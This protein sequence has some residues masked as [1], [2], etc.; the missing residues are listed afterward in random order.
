MCL[1]PLTMYRFVNP[2]TGAVCRS[3]KAVPETAL[4]Y[5]KLSLPCGKCIECLQ[6]YSVEWANRC[7]LEAS[8][9]KDNCVIALTYSE[10]DGSLCRRD[11][12]LF[13]KRL[14]KAVSVPLRFFYCGEYGKRGGRP[15]Y[16]VIVFG[17]KPPDL[18]FF[19]ERDGHSVYKSAFVAR[20]WSDGKEWLSVPRKAGFISVED[21]TS[22]SAKY[23]AKY[24]QK[25]NSI[26]DGLVK[27]FTGMSLKPAIG[28]NGFNPSWFESDHMYINGRIC[29]IP[30][31]FRRKFGNDGDVA[32][33]KLRGEL[34]KSS[35]SS[36][37]SEAKL[38]FGKVR[39]QAR[40]FDFNRS[41]PPPS[42]FSRADKKN[43]STSK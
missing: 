34:L 22:L 35:L 14:R 21:L 41:L 5:E 26:P 2:E 12:Q 3:F 19:F 24:L 25:L 32:A 11:V 36:R 8:C 9:H 43:H 1:Y 16:H 37:R 33:R 6:S 40:Y 27:P 38:R 31:Y 17:W 18:E 39:V 10:T 23:C 15:H 7:M 29:S 13:L 4:G 30:R 20:V 28:L 42:T